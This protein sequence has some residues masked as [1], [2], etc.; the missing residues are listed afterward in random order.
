MNIKGLNDL[1]VR[2]MKVGV[3]ES[4]HEKV[5]INEK[6]PALLPL[7]KYYRTATDCVAALR[8]G[9]VNALILKEPLA[10][11]NTYVP[12]C[13]G[14]SSMIH[15][16][17]NIRALQNNDFRFCTLCFIKLRLRG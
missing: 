6:L 16:S 11:Y 2:G 5:W 3:V 12:P 4:S 15:S 13:T 14:I 7:V 8:A 1:I 17:L 10:L 9:E